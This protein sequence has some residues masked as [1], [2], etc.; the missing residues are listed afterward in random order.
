M[1]RFGL[2]TVA[3]VF[4]LATS[5]CTFERTPDPELGGRW[6]SCQSFA[7]SGGYPIASGADYGGN[8]NF[9]YLPGY[10]PV[11]IDH[12][13]LLRH[14]EIEDAL[15]KYCQQVLVPHGAVAYP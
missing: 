6:D 13:E 1:R 3:L 12:D 15:M 10:K 9:L 11:P 7:F 8:P 14:L 5:G 2:A 4:A